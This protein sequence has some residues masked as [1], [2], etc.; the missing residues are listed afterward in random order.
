MCRLKLKFDWIWK[1]R[2][3]EMDRICVYEWLSVSVPFTRWYSNLINRRYYRWALW[4]IDPGLSADGL[5]IA[6]I[7]RK[8]TTRPPPLSTDSECRLQRRRFNLICEFRIQNSKLRVRLF[9]A[10]RVKRFSVQRYSVTALWGANSSFGL[11]LCK[12]YYFNGQE[13]SKTHFLNCIWVI[14]IMI[15][16]TRLIGILIIFRPSLIL[17]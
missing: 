11:Q 7:S 12:K 14:Q 8:A 6:L 17:P 9:V 16:S 13:L 5:S 15:L 10:N 1:L 2:R 4:R 3:V